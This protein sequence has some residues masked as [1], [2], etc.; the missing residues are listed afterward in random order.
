MLLNVSR[1]YLSHAF[2]KSTGMVV[3]YVISKRLVYSQ[4]ASC[5]RCISNRGML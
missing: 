5:R 1:Y 3:D 2:K 4:K